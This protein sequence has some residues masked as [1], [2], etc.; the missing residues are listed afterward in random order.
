MAVVE[1][2]HSPSKEAS[3]AKILETL[4][5]QAGHVVPGGGARRVADGDK[6]GKS[7]RPYLKKNSQKRKRIREA[8]LK[9][10]VEALS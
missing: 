6:L 7:L 8:C 1:H 3:L 2:I 5:Q 10:E 9:E 4:S